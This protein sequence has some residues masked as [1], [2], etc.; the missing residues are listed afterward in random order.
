M[1]ADL[2]QRLKEALSDVEALKDANQKLDLPLQLPGGFRHSL[3]YFAT[4]CHQLLYR[5]FK[6]NVQD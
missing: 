6:A 4:R 5:T 3:V 1:S 2:D